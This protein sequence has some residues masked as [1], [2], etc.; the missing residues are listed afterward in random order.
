MIQTT[1]QFNKIYDDIVLELQAD[2]GILTPNCNSFLNTKRRLE[3]F[4]CPATCNNEALCDCVIDYADAS[5]AQGQQTC[6]SIIA[7]SYKNPDEI[8]SCSPNA[9][10]MAWDIYYYCPRF[11]CLDMLGIGMNS[12]NMDAYFECLC[13]AQSTM[14]EECKKLK[15]SVTFCKDFMSTHEALCSEVMRC[16]DTETNMEGLKNATKFG[17]TVV[18]IQVQAQ[19]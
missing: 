15:G 3:E 11:Q 14:C 19:H 17:A 16:C 2:V 10:Y 8:A 9:Y 7:T 1:L 13:E 18:M 6:T 12:N 5:N 4:T